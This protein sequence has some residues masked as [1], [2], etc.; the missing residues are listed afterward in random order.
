M[1]N[2]TNAE[3]LREIKSIEA[4]FDKVITDHETRLKTTERYI[5]DQIA[6][7]DYVAKN[8][9]FAQK[10]ATPQPTSTDESAKPNN[11]AKTIAV[12]FGFFTAVIGLLT[13]LVQLTINNK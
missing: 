5:S 8:G 7:A 9:T 1:E 3:L 2:P 12:V 10:A 11:L 13:Y 6:V 4:K